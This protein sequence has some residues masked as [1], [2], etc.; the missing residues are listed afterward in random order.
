MNP[1]RQSKKFICQSLLV[2]VAFGAQSLRANSN[3]Q[4][5]GLYNIVNSVDLG[6][7]VRV[8]LHVRLFNATEE[9]LFITKA[10]LHVLL[11]SRSTSEEPVSAILEPHGASEFTQEFTVSYDEYEIWQRGV[12]PRLSVKIQVAGGEKG[13]PMVVLVRRPF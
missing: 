11:H 6:P 12:R 2:L 13:A 3:Q 4:I 1:C 7:D 9:T 10:G 8:T 5:T